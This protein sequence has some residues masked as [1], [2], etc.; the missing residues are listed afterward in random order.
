VPVRADWHP[1][2]VHSGIGMKIPRL[3]RQAPGLS[4]PRVSPVP[5]GYGRSAAATLLEPQSLAGGVLA[6]GAA[7]RRRPGGTADL[8]GRPAGDHCS[9]HRAGQLAALSGARPG[10]RPSGGIRCLRGSTPEGPRPRFAA[11]GAVMNAPRTTQALRPSAHHH[12]SRIHV[13]GPEITRA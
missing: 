11:A 2:A 8:V 6:G 5:G 10:Q 9:E 12:G 4:R 1:S 13:Q 7:G 3:S